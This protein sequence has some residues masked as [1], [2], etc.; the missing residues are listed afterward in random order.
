MFYFQLLNIPPDFRSK[1]SAIQLVACAKSTDVKEFG[2]K[3]LLA[4]FIIGLQKLYN[5]C[6]LTVCGSTK[7]YHGLLVY[8]LGDTLAAQMLGGFKE[9]V[10]SAQ[11]PCRTCE[12]A[13]DD[14]SNSRCS[15][16]FA[17]RDENEYRDRCA[18]L[19]EL[20]AQAKAYWSQ[21]YGITRT[22]CLAEIPAF[23]LTECL[24]HDPMQF[25]SK[26]QIGFH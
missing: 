19:S 2:F 25:C 9:G 7:L 8:V 5:G 15:D 12:I 23:S 24:L 16:D 4:D 11:K 10:G 18:M 22:S 14:L 13:R 6:T 1:L 26:E 17:K 21:Q 20:S 3:K